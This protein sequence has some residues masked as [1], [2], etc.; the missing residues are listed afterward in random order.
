[1]F[2]KCRARGDPIPGST[3]AK[4]TGK[5]NIKGCLAALPD[6]LPMSGVLSNLGRSTELP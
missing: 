6:F 2:R 5:G 3:E 1:M 4:N